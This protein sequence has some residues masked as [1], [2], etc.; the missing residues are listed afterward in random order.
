MS[1]LGLIFGIETVCAILSNFGDEE[2]CVRLSVGA[3]SAK[4]SFKRLGESAI[5]GVLGRI[6]GA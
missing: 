5:L 6:F 2:H 4:V 1:Y 3:V